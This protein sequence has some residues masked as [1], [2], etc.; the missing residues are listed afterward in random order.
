LLS[1]HEAK[2]GIAYDLAGS[3][4]G[5]ISPSF[6]LHYRYIAGIDDVV[7]CA[8]SAAQRVDRRMLY[9]DKGI[10]SFIAFTQVHQSA[11]NAETLFVWHDPEIQYMERGFHLGF[12]A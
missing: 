7:W 4:E 9:K 3:M 5:D 2:N 1:F 12:T 11:L 6:D 10:L 8:S